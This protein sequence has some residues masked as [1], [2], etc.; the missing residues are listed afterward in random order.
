MIYFVVVGYNC[1]KW[2]AKCLKSIQNQEETEWKAVAIDDGS[3]DR[4]FKELLKFKSDERFKLVDWPKNQGAAF[5]RYNALQLHEY[6]DEDIIFLVD[7]DDWL[8]H[9]NVLNRV[10]A[11]YR[12]GAHCTFGSYVTTDGQKSAYNFHKDNI[13]QTEYFRG[14]AW[15][16]WH[17]RTFKYHLCKHLTPEWFQWPDGEWIRICTD[18]ALLQPI[19]ERCRY[20]HIHFIKDRLYMYNNKTGNSARDRY[21]KDAARETVRYITR[22]H[23][24]LTEK[25]DWAHV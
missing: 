18:V 5:Q 23:R 3:T 12:K 2:V 14:R 1:E 8:A 25:I 7:M 16:W 15:C 11:E 6:Q 4:T 19:A 10:L 20:P 13:L 9:D 24:Q 21:G 17:P 22:L